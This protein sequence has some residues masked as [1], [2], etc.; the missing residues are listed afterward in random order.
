MTD[1]PRM[2][3]LLYRGIEQATE[4][5]LGLGRID[6]YRIVK[7]GQAIALYADGSNTDQPDIFGSV[8][9]HLNNGGAEA[10]LT[11]FRDLS[12]ARQQVFNDATS[13]LKATLN[14]IDVKVKVEVPAKLHINARVAAFYR[15]RHD[16]LIGGASIS[17]PG[18]VDGAVGFFATKK[19]QTDLG[20]VEDGGGSPVL[21]SAGHI[22][23]DSQLTPPPKPQV[24]H[25]GER[26]AQGQG[27]RAS[28]VGEAGSGFLPLHGQEVPVD[29]AYAYLAKNLEVAMLPPGESAHVRWL[30][31]KD[32]TPSFYDK[33]LVK[34]GPGNGNRV[35]VIEALHSTW[36][37]MLTN[38]KGKS[39]GYGRVNN[40]IRV[41][42]LR[43]SENFSQASDSG[44]PV[45]VDLGG[46][47][48]ALCGIIVG[49]AKR[50][51]GREAVSFISPIN[52]IKKHLGIEPFIEPSLLK[53]ARNSA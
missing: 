18:L 51:S 14:D 3:D 39:K 9:A 26:T 44:S 35:G 43:S 42:P 31:E 32:F 46:G 5:I 19:Q 36:P 21:V 12:K 28:R 27:L 30:E 29:A 17:G 22:L 13:L 50:S 53:K 10:R 1:A 11:L 25:P 2:F 37:F 45:V 48:F 34:F 6:G 15:Q 33:T 52:E 4:S 23:L 49:G 20:V 8:S 38:Y 16:P 40:V 47:D 41:K 24:L 7:Y